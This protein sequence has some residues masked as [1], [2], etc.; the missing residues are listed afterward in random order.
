MS[1]RRSVWLSPENLHPRSPPL[2]GSETCDVVVVGGGITGITAALLL[3]RQGRSVALLEADRIAAGTTG[4]TT[5]KV[6]SQH[7]LIYTGLVARHGWDVARSYAGA[8]EEAVRLIETLVRETAAD[9]HFTKAS[10]IVYDRSGDDV[11]RL[12]AEFETA[13]DLGL[14][15]RLI[16]ETGLPFEVSAALEFQGQ[17]YFHPVRYC[18]ALT[19][20]FLRIGGRLHEDTRVIG[21]DESRS[22]VEAI[23]EQGSIEA[24]FAL[25]ATLL[26]FVSRGGFFAKTTPSRAYGVAAR[27]ASPCPADMYISSSAP[28]RSLRPWPDAGPNGVIIVGESHPTGDDQAGPGRWG[29]LERW[30]NENFE[31]ESF[32]YRWSAQDYDTADGIPYVGRSPLT[33]RVLVATGFAKWG[34]TNGTAA[35]TILSDHVLGEQNDFADAFSAKRIGDLAAV[36]NMVT[37]NAAIAVGMV[38]DRV[39]R[40]ALPNVA[41]LDPG[42]AGIFSV[43]KATAAV[44]R[45][46][47][48]ARHALSPNCTH[49]G[50]GVRWN[51]AENTWDCP[52]HG[53]RF[54]IDGSVLSGPATE[55]LDQIRLDDA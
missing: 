16:Q 1:E 23:T 46:P 30:A 24:Q 27:L 5:G 44:Y 29:E 10:A 26:P 55:P 45:D 49:L 47:S 41:E 20:E 15:A 37:T 7:G 9:C 48:G 28:I 25:V 53:S 3:Q 40:L 18:R 19:R 32:E 51:D 31:V 35:A 6:T 34:L 39:G 4:G 13:Q 12:E 33:E 11:D 22:R 8:N 14:P 2:V 52:C 21:V 54:D 42:G 43:D 17:A 38:A 36:A 50:C